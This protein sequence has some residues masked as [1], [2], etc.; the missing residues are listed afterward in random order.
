MY[1]RQ[2]TIQIQFNVGIIQGKEGERAKEGGK[3]KIGKEYRKN[4]IKYIIASIK[5]IYHSYEQSYTIL[6]SK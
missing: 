1:Q 4:G 6:C 2:S 3:L 5:I